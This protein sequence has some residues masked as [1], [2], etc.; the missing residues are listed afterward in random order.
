MCNADARKLST[1]LE[2]D[3]R[4]TVFGLRAYSG[5]EL[6]SASGGIC[7]GAHTENMSERIHMPEIRPRWMLLSDLYSKY[8][9]NLLAIGMLPSHLSHEVSEMRF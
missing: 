5:C 9:R 8:R 1:S 4:A 3:V 6:V 7:G 2:H